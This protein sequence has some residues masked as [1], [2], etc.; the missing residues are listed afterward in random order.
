MTGAGA[1][2]DTCAYCNVYAGVAI[3]Y[4]ATVMRSGGVY[5]IEAVTQ[6]NKH[7]I[8][9]H[10]YVHNEAQAIESMSSDR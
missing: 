7:D 2:V 5:T 3:R 10:T 1:R 4:V 6:C 9:E 8:R